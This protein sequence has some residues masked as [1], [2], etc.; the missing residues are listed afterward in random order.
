MSRP[1]SRSVWR[2]AS[3]IEPR[4][5]CD[6]PPEKASIAA[7]TASTPASQA[8]RTVAA[9]APEVSWVWKWIGRPSSCFSVLISS[10]AAAG[11][12]RPGHVFQAEHMGAG[13]FQL[14]TAGDVVFQVIFGAGGVQQVAGI[15]DGAF[16][17]L[18]RL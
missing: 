12:I 4:Q 16:A 18:V 15:A 10:L 11:F 17:D 5:G 13:G 14:L 6:V 2:S 8:A 7:S 1:V 3:T 9:A